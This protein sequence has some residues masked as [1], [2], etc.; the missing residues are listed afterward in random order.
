MNDDM[1]DDTIDYMFDHK[2][3]PIRK[4][5]SGKYW[6]TK[7]GDILEISKMTDNHIINC[8]RLLEQKVKYFEIFKKEIKKRKLKLKGA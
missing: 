7:N 3:I 8:Y 1:L 4:N 6:K 2:E 5:V